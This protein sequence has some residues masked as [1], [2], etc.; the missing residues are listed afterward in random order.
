[1]KISAFLSLFNEEYRIRYT[2]QSLQWCDEIIVVDKN[3]TDK[4]V[5]ICK[6][7]GAKVF[8]MENSSSYDPSEL[9]FLKE[10]TGDW[11]IIVTASDIIDKSLA[12]EIKRQIELLPEDVGCVS[13]P[14]KN[15]ILGIE[16]ERS[17][18][19]F[20]HMVKVLR[21]GNY[22]INNDV[23]GALSIINK[24]AHVISDK[25]GYYY[26]LT[27]VSLDM[28][29]D[30]H[31]RYWRGEAGMYNEKT[32]IPAFKN[33]WRALKDTVRGRKTFLL[34][35]DGVALTFA[36]VSYYM[37]SFLYIWEFRRRDKASEIYKKIREKNFE[38]W[39]DANIGE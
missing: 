21:N 1:M 33:F 13:L 8:E 27:H 10:C 36:Y 3:S 12:K 23:H 11:I 9:N 16:D 15:Y 20:S 25:F 14:F 18:W 19:H 34:G 39:E 24:N 29:L 32:M 5:E 37:F 38:E 35:W 7:Y 28:M 22:T 4:T 26:H 2:L 30:R 31:I 6:S 17:P